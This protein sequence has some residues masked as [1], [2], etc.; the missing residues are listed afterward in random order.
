L[1]R[2]YRG[3]VGA[4][5]V[6]DISKATSF[7]NLDKWLGELNE[8]ADP[9]CC[10]MIVGNKVDLKHLREVTSDEGRTLAGLLLFKL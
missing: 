5:V 6:F 3:A 8:H 10:I 1:N 4:L 7:E 2:Y 9:H